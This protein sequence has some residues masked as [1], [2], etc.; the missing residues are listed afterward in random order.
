M[1]SEF[2]SWRVAKRPGNPGSAY[3]LRE[4]R[5]ASAARREGWTLARDRSPS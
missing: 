4:K 2:E 5:R 1:F 3:A